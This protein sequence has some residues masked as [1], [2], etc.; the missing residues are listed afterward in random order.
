MARLVGSAA[1]PRMSRARNP[2]LRSTNSRH[3]LQPCPI[4]IRCSGRSAPATGSDNEFL[5]LGGGALAAQQLWNSGLRISG[6]SCAAH[7]RDTVAVLQ[8]ARGNRSGAVPV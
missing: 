4:A 5:I 2:A 6:V 1:K 3:A 7:Q 8:R